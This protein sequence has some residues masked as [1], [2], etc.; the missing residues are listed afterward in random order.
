MM[1]HHVCCN[2]GIE[3]ADDSIIFDLMDGS[4]CCFT[5]LKALAVRSKVTA[6]VQI[7]HA[8]SPRPSAFTT[9]AA[10]IGMACAVLAI[11]AYNAPTGAEAFSAVVEHLSGALWA[12]VAAA[13]LWGAVWEERHAG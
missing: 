9:W 4:W 10:A 3:S 12:G 1:M 11:A 7:H 6:Q 8:R 2:C 5:C 13:L